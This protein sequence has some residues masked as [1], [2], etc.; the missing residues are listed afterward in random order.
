MNKWLKIIIGLIVLTGIILLVFPNMPMESWGRAALTL[1][2][3]GITL[4]AIF[5][6]LIL[7]VLGIMDLK[8]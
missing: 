4:L 8:N 3:G 7:I 2:K 5:V 6:G 1:I